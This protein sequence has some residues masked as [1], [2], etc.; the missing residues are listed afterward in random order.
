[1]QVAPE[2]S[3]YW[4]DVCIKEKRPLNKSDYSRD[5]VSIGQ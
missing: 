4:N 2:A 1:M 5:M 3:V